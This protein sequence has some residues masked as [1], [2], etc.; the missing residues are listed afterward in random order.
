MMIDP[1][2]WDLIAHTWRGGRF[3]YL[4]TNDDGEGAKYTYWRSADWRGDLP[5]LF[6]DKDTYFGVNPSIIRRSENERARIED[7]TV[8]NCLFAEFDLAPGQT[9]E[10][11]LAEI[12][13]LPV[14]PSV[15][16]WSGGGY[17]CYWFLAQTYHANDETKREH[18]ASIQAAWVTFV[19]S[20]GAA[21][22]LARVLRV[23]GTT[24]WKAKYSPN[25]P[26]VEIVH[27]EPSAQYDLADLEPHLQP[28]LDQ[29]NAAK[30]HT[31]HPPSGTV[32][33]SDQE[34]LNILFN[35]KNGDRYQRLWN[36][37]YSMYVGG[38]GKPDQSK[39]SLVLCGG[40]A[41]VTNRDK[42]RM[43]SLFRQSGLMR[44]KWDERR[45][46][47][48]WGSKMIDDAADTAQQ[49]IDPNYNGTANLNMGTSQTA[50]GSGS[51][52]GSPPPP[53]PNGTS[54]SQP[55]G[56][57]PPTNIDQFLLA[58]GANDEGNAQ[59]VYA[60]YGSQFLYCEAYGYLH[61]N[62]R[63]WEAEKAE[64]K[65]RRAITH[66]LEKR[67]ILGLRNGQDAL[68]RAAKPNASNVKNCM[69]MFQS[70]VVTDVE[71]FDDSPETINC[72]NG[73]VNLRTGQLDPHSPI[74]RYTYC[75]PVDYDPAA[76]YVEWIE[77]L[78]KVVSHP[79]LIDYLQMAVGYTAT[80]DTREECLF[81]VHGPTRSGKG[82]FAETLL[83][84]LKKPL[85]V[86]ADFSTFTE[87]R[88][89]DSQNFDL[90][91]LKPARFVVASESNKYDVLNEAKV[92]TATG[93]DWIRCAFKHKSHFEYKPQ[94]KIWLLSNH[95]VKGDVDDDAFWGRVKVISFPNSFLGKEDKALKRRMKSHEMLRGVLRWMVEGAIA[96]FASSTGLSTPQTVIDATATRRKELDYV[97]Q[98]LDECCKT[99]PNEWTSNS[100]IRI[101][102]ESWCKAEGI[103]PKGPEQ[104]SRALIQ[105][106]YTVGV[107]KYTPLG[108]Q[109]RG[110]Q[111]LSII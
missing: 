110:V 43:D 38:D 45:G 49:T 84:L 75:L 105:K 35:S 27:W 31:P 40:L 109:V 73:V 23:P 8:L 111:G 106:G 103:T 7:I 15:I 42:T 74:Q 56:G 61:Y 91:P 81:Y 5:K 44:D 24:N 68:L 1:R 22:D 46:G 87:K 102:Y 95:P 54:N 32:S 41:L 100:D 36:G 26:T 83:H 21:K 64:A 82:T 29:R 101:S 13:A 33:L 96:W 16:V 58:Q 28:I 34:L 30:A 67:A 48:T 14:P 92:K 59:S 79:E 72:K 6:K 94:F 47:G 104:F 63:F 39:A 93:G 57:T 51:N 50:A 98:W 9:P 62:G 80:G 19:G 52:G 90:A 70:L 37:D 65:L 66:T 88:D 71:S 77:F 60:L 78:S 12:K 4:W 2:F 17:H 11:L 10:D 99:D 53:P 97:Q 86:Q 3:G 76:D 89:G 18:I 108:K 85:G 55:S 107:R 25:F 20:D 69:Y